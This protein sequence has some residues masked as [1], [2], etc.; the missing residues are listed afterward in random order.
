MCR[1]IA[2]PVGY[3][4]QPLPEDDPRLTVFGQS[5]HHRAGNVLKLLWDQAGSSTYKVFRFLLTGLICFGDQCLK[6]GVQGVF[7]E[8]IP[9]S[10][11]ILHKLGFGKTEPRAS[12]PPTNYAYFLRVLKDGPTEVPYPLQEIGNGM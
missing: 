7:Y 2:A 9:P 11:F 10:D 3:K 1:D 4:H 6:R 12:P 5:A 8:V